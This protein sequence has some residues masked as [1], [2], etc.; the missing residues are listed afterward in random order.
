MEGNDIL[1][2]EE[3][4]HVAGEGRSKDRND[5]K[6]YQSLCFWIS[7]WKKGSELNCCKHSS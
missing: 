1:T 7:H 2:L 5:M 6:L 4:R 3:T